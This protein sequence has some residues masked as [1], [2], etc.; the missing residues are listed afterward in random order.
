MVTGAGMGQATHDALGAG[1][2]SDIGVGALDLDQYAL[3]L[4]SA[5]AARA[6]V[7]ISI[8]AVMSGAPFAM[9]APQKAPLFLAEV[10]TASSPIAKQS[11]VCLLY[12]S[13]SPRDGLLSRMPS[14]A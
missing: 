6:S 2:S 3:G 5:L 10:A 1:R 14:S 13:P 9:A 8:A 11:A 4:Q 12:T 7:G